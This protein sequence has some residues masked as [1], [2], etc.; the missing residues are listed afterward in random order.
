[1]SGGPDVHDAVRLAAARR[2]GCLLELPLNRLKDRPAAQAFQ[3]AAVQALGGTHCGYKIGATSVEVQR[4]LGCREPFYGPIL[5]QDVLPSGSP[6]AMMPGLLGLECEFG[7]ELGGVLPEPRHTL[8]LAAVKA[9]VSSCFAAL[10]IVGRRVPDTVLLNEASSIADFGLDVAVIRG[11]A[12]PQ[13]EQADL[14]TLPVRAELDGAVVASGSGAAVLGNPLNALLWLARE[15][16]RSGDRLEAGAIVLTG[17]CTG[18]T[19]VASGQSFAG[20]FADL[21]PVTVRLT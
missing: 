6:F 8:D 1:M 7:F 15:L 17:T 9:A 11:A 13:W 14:A 3:A 16:A 20:R 12:I 21:P 10:E 2:G 19:P 5:Q 18:I 4:R